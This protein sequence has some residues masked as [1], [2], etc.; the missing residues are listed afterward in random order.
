MPGGW[1]LLSW[2]GLVRGLQVLGVLTSAILNGFLLV[3]IHLN[4][5]GLSAS[6]FA[7]ELMTCAVLIYTAIVL[8]VQHT[9]NRSWKRRTRVLVTIVVFDVIF[10]GLMMGIITILARTGVP[11]NC[12]G[13]T[14]SDFR[15]GDRPD[16]PPDGYDTIR[17]GGNSRDF[18]GALDKF[19]ALERAYYFISLAIIF[20]YMTTVTLSMLLIY[21]ELYSPLREEPFGTGEELCRLES[22]RSQSQAAPVF[23][24]VRSTPSSP[25][26]EVPTPWAAPSGTSSGEG[27]RH[28]AHAATPPASA[29]QQPAPL[30]PPSPPTPIAHHD[31][32]RQELLINQETEEDQAAEAA[33]VTDGYRQPMP[34]GMPALPPYTPG[35]SSRFMDGHGLE[36]NEMRLSGYVKG[37]TRAQNMRDGGV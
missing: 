14:R 28:H 31:P 33:M 36:S 3:Y 21:E 13:L 32:S 2:L 9:G 29:P 8:L 7:L 6:M 11:S 1:G 19:C 10:T 25:V 27:S 12:A 16:E 18:K 23:S 20:S 34:H 22:K 35:E 5:L 37:E 26:P 30:P 17:F 15:K 24:P 4:K